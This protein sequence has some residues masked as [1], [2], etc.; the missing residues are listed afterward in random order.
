MMKA[1]SQNPQSASWR[2]RKASDVVSVW[3]WEPGNQEGWWWS[4][5]PEAGRLDAQGEVTFQLKSEGRKKV[6]VRAQ[7]QAGRPAR[8]EDLAPYLWEDQPF[9]LFRLSSDR[10]RLTHIGEGIIFSVC[11]FLC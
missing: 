5:G 1:E 4:S 3:V 7:R 2:P 9:V 10:M 8:Q 6:G 11:Q